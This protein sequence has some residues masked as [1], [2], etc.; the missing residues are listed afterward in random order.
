MAGAYAQ[1][2][3]DIKDRNGLLVKIPMDE[4]Y[5]RSL[6]LSTSVGIG[7]FEARLRIEESSVNTMLTSSNAAHPCL[8]LPAFRTLRNKFSFIHI[9]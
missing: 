7:L 5:V 9:A 6:N 1:A 3:Q 8:Y 4:T 2:A